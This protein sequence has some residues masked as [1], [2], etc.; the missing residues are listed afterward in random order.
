MKVL[1][2]EP[3]DDFREV[4]AILLEM[5]GYTVTTASCATA[6]LAKIT[7]SV[8]DAVLTEI[9]MDDG[10][11]L[12]A[13]IRAMPL[14][15]DAALV[16][17]TGFIKASSEQNTLKLGFDYFLPK[18]IA[19]HPIVAVLDAVAKIKGIEPTGHRHLGEH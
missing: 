1:L 11:E 2:V 16:A 18:P 5:L 17:L 14:A 4:F 3:D 12:A 6:A 13:Q 10:I 7:K 19:T 15:Q 8:P 9:H